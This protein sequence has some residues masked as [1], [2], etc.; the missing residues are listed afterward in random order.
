MNKR[1]TKPSSIQSAKHS[2]KR[3]LL[4]FNFRIKIVFQT[5]IKYFHGGNGWVRLYTH[6]FVMLRKHFWRPL[7]VPNIWDALNDLAP[8][9]LFQK[10]KKYLW[11]NVTF[12]LNPASLFKATFLHR[13]FSHFFNCTNCAK[14]NKATYVLKHKNVPW[15]TFAPNFSLMLG[16]SWQQNF[17]IFRRALL[18]QKCMERKKPFREFFHVVIGPYQKSRI[19]TGVTSVYLFKVRNKLNN[20]GEN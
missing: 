13:C 18:K 3:S 20:I 7:T 8:F 10:R 15:T 5:L 4:P 11:R 12:R 9:V 16:Q 1:N 14:L 17:G 19:A 2:T 6:H